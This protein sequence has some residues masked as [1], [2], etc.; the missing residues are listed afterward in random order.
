M[1]DKF[2]WNI[3]FINKTKDALIRL[4]IFIN[5]GTYESIKKVLKNVF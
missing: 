3:I 2:K 4:K 5:I 1:E